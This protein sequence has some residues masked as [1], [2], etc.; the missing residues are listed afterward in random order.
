MCYISARTNLVNGPPT[1]AQCSNS[2]ILWLWIIKINYEFRGVLTFISLYELFQYYFIGYCL[3]SCHHV[4]LLVTIVTKSCVPQDQ[5]NYS[6]ICEVMLII[7]YSIFATFMSNEICIIVRWS[8]GLKFDTHG[9]TFLVKINVV[10]K[11][12]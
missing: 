5:N 2:E 12:F 6:F 9:F 8:R 4:I 1:Q 3:Y 10:L 11:K 7:K